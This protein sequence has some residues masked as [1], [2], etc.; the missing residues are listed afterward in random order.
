MSHNL[1]IRCHKYFDI[2]W[3]QE[4]LRSFAPQNDMRLDTRCSQLYNPFS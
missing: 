4:M 3:L 1:S 2:N